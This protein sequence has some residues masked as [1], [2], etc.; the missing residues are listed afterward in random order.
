[1][2]NRLEFDAGFIVEASLA[3]TP[4]REDDGGLLC[5]GATQ[6]RKVTGRG[7]AFRMNFVR[8]HRFAP[9]IHFPAMVAT[10]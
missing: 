6:S 10:K 5:S 9:R 2:L 4:V 1:M 3:G 8:T 7:R